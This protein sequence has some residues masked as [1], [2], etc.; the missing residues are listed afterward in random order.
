MSPLIP[1]ALRAQ[2][3]PPAVQGAARPVARSGDDFARALR[4]ETGDRSAPGAQIGRAHV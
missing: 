3:T 2:L 1:G 4:Q